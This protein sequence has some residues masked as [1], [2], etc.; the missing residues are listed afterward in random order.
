MAAQWDPSQKQE[1]HKT[2]LGMQMFWIWLPGRSIFRLW[3]PLADSTRPQK[4]CVL[5]CSS[6][7]TQWLSYSTALATSEDSLEE[8]WPM[9]AGGLPPPLLYYPA[10]VTMIWFPVLPSCFW[11]GAPW[12]IRPHHISSLLASKYICVPLCPQRTHNSQHILSFSLVLIIS[13]Y[14]IFLFIVYLLPQ[15]CSGEV[16]FLFHQ[17]CIHTVLDAEQVL[18]RVSG[19]W[20]CGWIAGHCSYY[21]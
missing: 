11:V 14:V 3:T 10:S 1:Q 19:W 20:V 16:V 5:D 2:L 18:R 9:E 21:R 15:E 6:R 17:V 8:L 4:M 12:A 7:C 13:D